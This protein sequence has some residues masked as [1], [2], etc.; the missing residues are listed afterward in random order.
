MSSIEE[1]LAGCTLFTSSEQGE[2]KRQIVR[3]TG[4][5]MFSSDPESGYIVCNVRKK[6]IKLTPEE[7]VRQLYVLYLLKS[8][9]PRSCLTLE[10]PIQIGSTAC[11]G[12]IVYQKNPN[13]EIPDVII[14]CKTPGM[15]QQK[16]IDQLRG[17]LAVTG[18]S[19]GVY[20]NGSVIKYFRQVGPND[21][22]ETTSVPYGFPD[23]LSSRSFS[24]LARI[25]MAMDTGTTD[26][27]SVRSSRQTSSSQ[28][29]SGSWWNGANSNRSGQTSSWSS[30][31]KTKSG[32]KSKEGVP[33]LFGRFIFRAVLL[34]I[35]VLVLGNMS[36]HCQ[37]EGNARV[38]ALF[39]NLRLWT[40]TLGVYLYL[41]F[42]AFQY[43]L[44][45]IGIVKRNS[46]ARR[47]SI[48]ATR[49]NH[50]FSILW[51]GA[52]GILKTIV[53]IVIAYFGLR[54][55]AGNDIQ[56]STLN[57]LLRDLSRLGRPVPKHDPVVPNGVPYQPVANHRP[58]ANQPIAN[59]PI[60]S[61]S[62]ANQPIGS[63]PTSNQPVVS[64]PISNR[65]IPNQSFANQPISN[66]PTSNQ[67]ISSQSVA[68]QPIANRPTSNQPI[69]NQSVANQPIANRPTS[70]QPT[71]NQPTASQSV[72]NQP[73]GNR[74]TS[75]QPIW[76]QPASNQPTA[77]RYA[78]RYETNNR[79]DYRQGTAPQTQYNAYGPQPTEY[80]QPLDPFLPR[81]GQS[82][83]AYSYQNS[84]WETPQT[85]NGSY[86]RLPTPPSDSDYP[87]S[88]GPVYRQNGGYRQYN[89][90]STQY[91][92]GS[93]NAR[94][95]NYGFLD[96]GYNQAKH[97]IPYE[98]YR[99]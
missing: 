40:I 85:Q 34:F 35:L 44:E 48:P 1:N 66:R 32:R 52:A 75:N 54:F 82:A 45:G 76:N 65:P 90:G 14:E 30:S 97:N 60:P 73:T 78:G 5:G 19:F 93:S 2:L 56:L 4:G 50:L 72:A 10:Y 24:M 47:Y 71:S 53:V 12:D 6:E 33:Q 8:G 11:R 91:G 67:P 88:Y 42:L 57:P 31:G 41:P 62:V 26:E 87:A 80:N 51:S 77:D 22:E 84:P 13:S 36:L 49:K 46:M 27:S 96:N 28:K 55:F 81:Y 20:M 17:Y 59:R 95:R 29:P 63:R 70:N 18:C 15:A 38:S 98:N 94:G 3:K 92:Q 16:Q 39:E 7:T 43:L 86:S 23:L 58:T 74:P 69:Q 79:S 61:Q 21:Y 99:Y 9:I 64:Q 37:G 83:F 89:S 25:R 68:N